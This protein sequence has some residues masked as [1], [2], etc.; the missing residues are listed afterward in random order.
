MEGEGRKRE[1]E[2]RAKEEIGQ[3][4][5]ERRRERVQEKEKESEA[6]E[7]CSVVTGAESENSNLVITAHCC[8]HGKEGRWRGGIG[9]E[10]ERDGTATVGEIPVS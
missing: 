10:V 8:L 3:R 6:G 2:R 5:R 1:R 4:E 7:L 9:L